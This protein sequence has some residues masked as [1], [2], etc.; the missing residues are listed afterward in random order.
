MSNINVHG[1]NNII[2]SASGDISQTVL[3]K[4]VKSSTE[5]DLFVAAKNALL[6]I[7]ILKTREKYYE[8]EWSER[9]DILS[10]LRKYHSQTN[11]QLAKELFS[12]LSDV[13]EYTRGT[14][15]KDIALTVYCLIVDFFPY[16]KDEDR[17]E[18]EIELIYLCC[19]L[20]FHIA[21]D[22]S[23]YAGDFTTVMYGLLMLKFACLKSKEKGSQAGIDRVK[24]MYNELE[25]LLADPHDR[26]YL[27]LIGYFKEDLP[28]KGLQF[29]M[30]SDNLMK[31]IYPERY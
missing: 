13:T 27:E 20:G 5:E 6:V 3:A 19:D 21:Y 16:L 10:T 28:K 22:N 2:N 1:D 30:L 14:L 23:I 29:P 24:K 31:L 8:A 11:F 7:E 18:K 12:F 4:E 15:P 26:N 25:R 17:V 9:G